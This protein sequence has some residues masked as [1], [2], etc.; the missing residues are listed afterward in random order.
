MTYLFHEIE[1]ALHYLETHYHLPILG[2]DLLNCTDF[3]LNADKRTRSLLTDPKVSLKAKCEI[4]TSS[5][6][7]QCDEIKSL[8]KEKEDAR[9]QVRL[10]F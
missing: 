8:E 1:T 4:L 7:K 2:T 5:L 6:D 3:L 9:K 10:I